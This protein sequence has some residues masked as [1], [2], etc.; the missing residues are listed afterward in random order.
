M[1]LY[2]GTYD[3]LIINERYTVGFRDLSGEFYSCG[4]VGFLKL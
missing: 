4:S 3:R 1:R 2:L